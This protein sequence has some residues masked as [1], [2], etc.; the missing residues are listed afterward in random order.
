MIILI[1]NRNGCPRRR[2]KQNEREK[3]HPRYCL[4]SLKQKAEKAVCGTISRTN[5]A[6]CCQARDEKSGI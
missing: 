5:P 4:S 3:S 2:K 1:Y 6:R